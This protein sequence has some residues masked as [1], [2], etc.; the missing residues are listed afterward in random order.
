[1]PYY[2]PQGWIGFGIKVLDKYDNGNNDWL[3]YNGNKNEWA[4]AYHG[5]G[6]NYSEEEVG[7][8]VGLIARDTLKPG[9]RQAHDKYDNIN[10]KINGKKKVGNGAYCTPNPNTMDKYAGKCNG[11]KMGVML[12]VYPKRIRFCKCKKDYWVLNPEEI[13]PYRILIKEI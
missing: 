4:V 9:D 5:V 10:R 2:P 7:K 1:M 8:F 13:R 12:R 6:Q 3:A 11:Y